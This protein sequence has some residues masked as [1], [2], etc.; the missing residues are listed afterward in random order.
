MMIRH[1]RLAAGGG[2]FF[3]ICFG[4]LQ[5]EKGSLSYENYW[6]GHVFAPVAIFLGAIVLYISLFKYDRI[7]GAWKDKRGRAVRFPADDFRLW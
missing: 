1:G 6:G 7:A 4:A 2:G 5:V 3:L